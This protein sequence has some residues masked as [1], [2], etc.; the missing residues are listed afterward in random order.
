MQN[1]DLDQSDFEDWLKN[2]ITAKLVEILNEDK[3]TL[4]Q[5]L[6]TINLSEPLLER[7]VAYIRGQ[8]TI[9]DL[10]LELSFNQ[11]FNIKEEEENNEEMQGYW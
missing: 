2:P 8:L 7:Q 9:Y 11:L 6:L 10:L 3:E 1:L 5:A 4:E